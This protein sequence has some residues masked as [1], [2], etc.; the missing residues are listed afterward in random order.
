MI[1][2]FLFQILIYFVFNYNQISPDFINDFK[3]RLLK[4]DSIFNFIKKL[5]LI[6]FEKF[7]I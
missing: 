6:K 4:I 2:T 3:Q 1:E 7:L 5:L